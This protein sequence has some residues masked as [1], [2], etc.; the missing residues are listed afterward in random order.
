[1]NRHDARCAVQ[2]RV[3]PPEDP[4]VDGIIA[5]GNDDFRCR[6]GLVGPQEGFTH[7]AADGAG[8]QK[9]IGVPGRSDKM[10]AEALH[11]VKRIPQ[12]HQFL[13]AGVCRAGGDHPDRQRAAEQLFH[14]CLYLP[15]GG[16]H[17]SRTRRRFRFDQAFF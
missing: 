8:Y 9:H 12:R 14:L 6:H 17:D 7:I 15:T 11:V 4:A 10:D 2:D 5:D 3:R 1:M 13:F 16:E